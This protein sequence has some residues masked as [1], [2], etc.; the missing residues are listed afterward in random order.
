MKETSKLNDMD[1]INT[2]RKRTLIDTYGVTA[3]S[4]IGLSTATIQ[5]L[6]NQTMFC[7]FV[8]GKTRQDALDQLGISEHTLYLYAIKYNARDLFMRPLRSQFE[9]EVAEW[10]TANSIEFVQ[11]SRD[12]I[13]PKEVDFFLPALNIAIECCGIYWHS[14]LSAGRTRTYH[15]DK[16]KA[17][18]E[19]GIQ[20]ITIFQDEWIQHKDKITQLLK[21]KVSRSLSIA[22]R[23]CEV[24]ECTAHQA[25]E[26]I[27]EHHLQGYTPSE[28]KIGLTFDDKLVAIMTFGKSRFSKSDQW[29]II[30]Y[31]SSMNITGGANK[32]LKNFIKNHNPSCIVSYSD[33]RYFTGAVYESMGFEQRDESIGYFYTDYKNRF[34]R[35]KF[36]KHKLVEQ[37]Y[38]A[39]MTEWEIMQ[40]KKFDRIWDCG[41]IKWVKTFPTN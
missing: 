21:N 37:G 18:R 5:I 20:L 30:R 4:R 23:K 27:N 6:D 31:C 9:V 40:L 39:L 19:V 34:N 28:I 25:T 14:E 24:I 22:A 7:E 3:A 41:Q 33:N 38:D 11:N 35:M 2:K 13:R 1:V 32:L 17:C 10:L 12:I 29:E 15:Y 8:T 26:F 36:Q 16:H